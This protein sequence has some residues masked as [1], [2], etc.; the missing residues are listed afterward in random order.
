MNPEI[1]KPAVAGALA[2]EL[3]LPT[4]QFAVLDPQLIVI[5]RKTNKHKEANPQFFL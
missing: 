2:F 4:L 1:L 3:V 5:E